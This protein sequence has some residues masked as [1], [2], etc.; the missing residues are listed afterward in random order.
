MACKLAAWQH[1]LAIPGAL[2]VFDPSPAAAIELPAFLTI[3]GPDCIT[4]TGVRLDMS[5]P[6]AAN[7]LKPSGDQVIRQLYRLPSSISSQSWIGE[8]SY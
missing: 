8:G 1:V 6:R 2:H 4:V 3:P 5:I 7:I